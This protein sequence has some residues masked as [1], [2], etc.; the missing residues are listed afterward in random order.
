MDIEGAESLALKGL[1]QKAGI[2]T[3]EWSDEQFDDT[4]LCVQRLKE[5]G[6]TH[7]GYTITNERNDLN[8]HVDGN[9]IDR[10]QDDIEYKPWDKFDLHEHV[11]AQDKDKWG[12]LYAKY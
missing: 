6:Y 3:F 4:M 2:I 10:Y 5:L 8:P 12:M 1:S 7:Y 11:N 9:L